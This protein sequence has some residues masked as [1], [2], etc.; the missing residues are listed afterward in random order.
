MSNYL[1]I[2][3]E[4]NKKAYKTTINK[5]IN[6]DNSIYTDNDNKKLSKSSTF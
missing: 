3:L 5:Q 1:N 4:N 2:L 6:T